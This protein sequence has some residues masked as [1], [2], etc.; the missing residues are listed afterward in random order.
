MVCTSCIIAFHSN[1]SVNYCELTMRESRRLNSFN[2]VTD[3][4]SLFVRHVKFM[5]CWLYS[6]L[7]AF[8]S[9]SLQIDVIK[10]L[11]LFNNERNSWTMY[12]IQQ[13]SLLSVWHLWSHKKVLNNLINQEKLHCC[14]S[15]V[16]LI[17]RLWILFNSPDQEA[18]KSDCSPKVA[19]WRS[20]N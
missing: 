3:S 14:S 13:F 6:C 11:R 4:P 17:I 9:K 8:D 18:T 7:P 1:F 10:C 12:A 15:T 16:K 19:L 2:V 20:T 5:V